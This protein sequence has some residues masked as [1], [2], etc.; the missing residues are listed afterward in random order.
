MLGGVR[1]IAKNGRWRASF[2]YSFT[3]LQ[4]GMTDAT[5]MGMKRRS[6]V[7]IEDMTVTTIAFPPALHDRLRRAA[8]EQRVALAQIVRAACEAWLARR[9]PSGAGTSS[10]STKKPRR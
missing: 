5:I 2:S 9:E 4:L 1:Q 3:A 10:G 6:E 8:F 7:P